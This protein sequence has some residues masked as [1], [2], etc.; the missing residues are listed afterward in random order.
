MRQVEFLERPEGR[1]AYEDSGG[2]GPLVVCSPGMGDLR[3][4]YRF[5]VPEF[6][7][8]GYRI[9]TTDLRGMGQ[10]TVQWSD[11][12]ES[13]IGSDLVALVEHLKAGP[14]VLIANSISA[15]AAVWAAAEAPERVA[16]LVLVG[17]FVRQVPIPRLREFLF[18]LALARP[19]GVATWVGYQAKNLYPTSKPEDLKRYTQ[20]VKENLH[21]PGRMRA[22]QR[23]AST[24]HKAA[25]ARLGRVRAPVLV[26]MGTADPDFP[27]PR[28]EALLVAKEL[29][30]TAILLDGAGHYPQ[31]GMPGVF[32]QKVFDFLSREVHGA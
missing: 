23:M 30:G 1:I 24:D 14:A 15:G 26:I 22:F 19:W 27:D 9:V 13:A 25:E 20:A 8:R 32:S 12:S 3:S 5:I 6:A 7:E 11:Y 29:R 16:G 31:A 17:P 28:A 18:R 2:A 10:S 21:E 4:V